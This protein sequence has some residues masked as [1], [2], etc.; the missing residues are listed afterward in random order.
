MKNKKNIDVDSDDEDVKEEMVQRSIDNLYTSYNTTISSLLIFEDLQ[1]YTL[2]RGAYDSY[3]MPVSYDD[4]R[5]HLNL[6]DIKK[7]RE[8]IRK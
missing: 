2:V 1:D 3:D 7:W 4:I 8:A 5:N 6:F